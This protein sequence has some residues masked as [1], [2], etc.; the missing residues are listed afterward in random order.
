MELEKQWNSASKLTTESPCATNYSRA[1]HM[2]SLIL[3]QQHLGGV[4]AS[5][6]TLLR[7]PTIKKFQ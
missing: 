5:S 7:I 4:Y 2:H 1:C 3:Y 6:F